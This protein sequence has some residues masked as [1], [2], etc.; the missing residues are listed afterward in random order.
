MTEGTAASIGVVGTA[1]SNNGERGNGHKHGKG[2][3]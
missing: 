1:A 2:W 3:T